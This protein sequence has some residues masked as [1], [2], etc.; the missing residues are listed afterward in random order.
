MDWSSVPP[1]EQR[2]IAKLFDRAPH[3]G[4]KDHLDKI[5]QLFPEEH[6]AQLLAEIQPLL[7]QELR[8]V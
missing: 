2:N 7:I 3:I 6:R 4:T 8:T 1:D 5:M